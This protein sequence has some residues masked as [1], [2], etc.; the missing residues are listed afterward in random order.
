[1][2]AM[3]L[4][5]ILESKQ[6]SICAVILK[7]INKLCIKV[8][9]SLTKQ[10]YQTSYYILIDMGATYLPVCFWNMMMSLK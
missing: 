1:M 6:F 5:I 2:M 3:L 10:F 9:Y 7:I 4:M 8:L